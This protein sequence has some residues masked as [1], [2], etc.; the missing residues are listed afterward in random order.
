MTPSLVWRREER[1][2]EHINHEEGLRRLGDVVVDG[3]AP[4]PQYSKP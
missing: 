3:Q 1:L 4:E 2:T